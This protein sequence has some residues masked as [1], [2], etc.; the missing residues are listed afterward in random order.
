MIKRL[1][2]KIAAVFTWLIGFGFVVAQPVFAQTKPWS[3]VCVSTMDPEVATIQ[4]IQC[5]IA[6]IFSVAITFIGLAG[7]VM[8]IIGAFNYLLSGGNSKDTE[9]AKNTLTF[10]IIGLVVSLSAFIILN[11]IAQF[12]GIDDLLEFTIPN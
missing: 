8:I 9:K 12:T 10:A 5:L 4:G 1:I 7:F 6:N 2:P 11:L 3:G